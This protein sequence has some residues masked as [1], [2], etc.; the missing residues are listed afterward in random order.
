MPLQEA[1]ATSAWLL[2]RPP[3]TNN[4][5][6]SNM[7]WTR[8]PISNNSSNILSKNRM[9]TTQSLNHTNKKMSG[10]T[11]HS[12]LRP[13]CSSKVQS[14]VGLNNSTMSNKPLDL[15]DSSSSS[16][17]QAMTSTPLQGITTSNSSSN[18]SVVSLLTNRWRICLFSAKELFQDRIVDPQLISHLWDFMPHQGERA[19]SPSFDVWIY[20]IIL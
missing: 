1:E 6:W 9:T 8:V 7:I 20:K 16:I 13:Q 15:G 19:V 12:T 4:Q 3:L 18:N 14:L 11:S 17:S 5:P 2:M 10:P